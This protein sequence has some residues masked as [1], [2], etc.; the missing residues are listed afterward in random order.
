MKKQSKCRICKNRGWLLV[1]K[2]SSDHP[3]YA[4]QKCDGCDRFLGDNEACIAVE[5][6]AKK[7]WK[8]TKQQKQTT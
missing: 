2:G 1:N 4:F 5:R 7:H 6:A 8:S 3:V